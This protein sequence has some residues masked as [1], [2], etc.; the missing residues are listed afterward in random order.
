MLVVDYFP[1]VFPLV[2]LIAA[3]R[4]EQQQRLGDRVANT[5][6]IRVGAEQPAALGA[7][8]AE[9]LLDQGGR[10]LLEPAP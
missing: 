2:G 4:S 3:L 1:Y 9:R 8:L 7:R 10:A 5:F 6:V